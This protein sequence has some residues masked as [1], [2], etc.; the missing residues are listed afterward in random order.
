MKPEPIDFFWT[1]AQI[2]PVA[3]WKI[4]KR[5]FCV[6]STLV[7]VTW[8]EARIL[9]QGIGCFLLLF[10]FSLCQHKKR[11]ELLF[12]LVFYHLSNG[13][14][15]VFLLLSRYIP[16]LKIWDR[17]KKKTRIWTPTVSG[18]SATRRNQRTTQTKLLTLSKVVKVKMVL[19]SLPCYIEDR[20]PAK[21]LSNVT[22]ES[23]D[24]QGSQTCAVHFEFN[25]QCVQTSSMYQTCLQVAE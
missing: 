9:V 1:I 13:L 23:E 24:D 10:M 20:R 11:E 6:V 5:F 3:F 17:N 8:G 22:R 15:D 25:I 2:N 12:R 21:V 19:N 7:Y 14:H 16:V 4:I 18:E